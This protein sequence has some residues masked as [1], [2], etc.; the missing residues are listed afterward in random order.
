M[1]DFFRCVSVFSA[2]YRD[3]TPKDF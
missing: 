3:G 2:V 1:I